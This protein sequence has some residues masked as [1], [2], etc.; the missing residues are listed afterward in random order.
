MF[1]VFSVST[2][3]LGEQRSSAGE[4]RSP[5]EAGENRKA[6]EGGRRARPLSPTAATMWFAPPNSSQNGA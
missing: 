2:H 4:S 1:F 3:A 6:R 5:A